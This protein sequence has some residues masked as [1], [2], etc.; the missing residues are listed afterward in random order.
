MKFKFYICYIV[1]FAISYSQLMDNV[2]RN[3]IKSLAI[4]GWGE[5]SLNYEERSKLFFIAEASLWISFF[6]FVGISFFEKSELIDSPF[7]FVIN[8]SFSSV[9]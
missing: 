1:L 8:I 3:A 7:V 2:D 6:L 9:N 5:K 4:P